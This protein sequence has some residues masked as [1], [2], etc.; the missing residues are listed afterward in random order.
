MNAETLFI[1]DRATNFVNQTILD[2]VNAQK[3]ASSPEI[4]DTP[5]AKQEKEEA[6]AKAVQEMRNFVPPEVNSILRNILNGF[7]R[8]SRGWNQYAIRASLE[9]LPFIG[10]NKITSGQIAEDYREA[11]TILPSHTGVTADGGFEA[12]IDAGIILIPQ[13]SKK[14]RNK[15]NTEVVPVLKQELK[16]R[17]LY[18]SNETYEDLVGKLDNLDSA[19]KSGLIKQIDI[20]P[21]DTSAIANKFRDFGRDLRYKNFSPEQFSTLDLLVL[22]AIRDF[23]MNLMQIVEISNITRNKVNESIRRLKESGSIADKHVR[24]DSLALQVQKFLGKGLTQSQIA[25]ILGPGIAEDMVR[26]AEKR[27]IERGQ[28]KKSN[29]QP[30]DEAS[31]EQNIVNLRQQ[32]F[33]PSQIVDQLDIPIAQVKG[34]IEKLIR[35]GKTERQMRG[36]NT[37]NHPIT[38][39]IIKI[40][41]RVGDMQSSNPGIAPKEIAERLNLPISI[42]YNSLYRL[43]VYRQTEQLI[44][45][46]K[47]ALQIADDMG[48]S[49]VK[50]K[51]DIAKLQ[52]LRDFQRNFTY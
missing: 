38:E 45:Q 10:L 44:Q 46:E 14:S 23:G 20:K 43:K 29:N 15:T 49:V 26:R 50:A 51:F 9:I 34:L 28:L 12:L 8:E 30:Q 48:V 6:F 22:E 13:M 32:G 1:K 21:I 11:V 25:H 3:L 33:S 19:L 35:E 5:V 36:R 27:L 52:K 42:V 47:T 18:T 7:A 37:L 17:Q 39:R 40:D 4:T 31:L 41:A 2:Q 24:E 16:K